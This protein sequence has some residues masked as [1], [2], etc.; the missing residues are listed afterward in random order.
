MNGKERRN[1][2]YKMLREDGSVKIHD[3]SVQF[4]VTRETARRDLYSLRM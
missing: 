2:I 3:L 1:R 4:Y